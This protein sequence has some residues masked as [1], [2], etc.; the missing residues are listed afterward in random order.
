MESSRIRKAD[1][2]KEMFL[3]LHQKLKLALKIRLGH[4]E[5]DQ[6]T[7]TS[8]VSSCS[9]MMGILWPG[10]SKTESLLTTCILLP[11]AS[12]AR[13]HR[14]SRL[15]ETNADGYAP[16]RGR[17]DAIRDGPHPNVPEARKLED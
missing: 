14:N 9:G 16:R 8:E 5:K 1:E 3:L 11:V 13:G 7:I 17:G 4:H 10:H 15:T 2:V 12:T 6:H